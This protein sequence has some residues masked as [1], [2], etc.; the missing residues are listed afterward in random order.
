[1]RTYKDGVCAWRARENDARWYDLLPEGHWRARRVSESFSSAAQCWKV[2]IN[3]CKLAREI[4]L[5][6]PL[7]AD[8]GT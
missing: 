4:E 8:T 3:H 7:G 2:Y 5:M 1:M 6:T